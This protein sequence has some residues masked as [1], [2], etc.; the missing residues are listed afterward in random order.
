MAFMTL[1]RPPFQGLRIVAR[2]I[3]RALPGAAIGH[4]FGVPEDLGP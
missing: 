1:V 3:P 4:A 2:Q